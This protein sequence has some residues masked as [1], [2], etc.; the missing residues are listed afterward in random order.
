MLIR[1]PER[2]PWSEITPEG[3]FLNRRAFMTGMAALALGGGGAA[4]ASAAPASAGT[5]LSAARNASFSLDEPLTKFESATTYNNFYE[6]GL[7]KDDPSRLAGSLK[8][9]PWTLKIEGEV[10]KPRAW[11]VDELVKAFPLEERVYSLRCVEGWSM[12]IPWIGFPLS[13][14]L[15]QVEPTG[16]A[17]FVEFYTLLDPA[18]FPGQKPGLFGGSALDWPYVEGLRLD[19]AMHPLTLVTVGMYGQVLPNQNGAPVR[20]VVPWKYG[21]KSAKS[22][23]RI[24]LAADQ[25]KTS[26]EKAASHEYGFYSNVNPAV[27]H[28]RWSQATERR[29]GEFRRRK[30]LP[31]NGY[32]DQVA[33]LYA[34]MDL[35]KFY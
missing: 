10:A 33:G 18:Q 24:R 15:K 8:P 5:P 21:F 2:F 23:V 31:F 30:T 27:D 17:R 25:P 32:G 6:F 20:I 19:E 14:V 1:R 12:V 35:K 9:R 7:N 13:A 26:W 4:S 29:I 16:K 3:V 22:I 34:G 28:P 11:D